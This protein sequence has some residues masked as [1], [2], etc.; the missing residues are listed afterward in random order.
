MQLAH[1]HYHALESFVEPALEPSVEAALESFVEA[2]VGGSLGVLS[3]RQPWSPVWRSC[4]DMLWLRQGCTKVLR[5]R[6]RGADLLS[7]GQGSFLSLRRGRF[8]QRDYSLA[9]SVAGRDT[10]VKVAAPHGPEPLNRN[11]STCVH[12]V[13]VL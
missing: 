4:A 7:R 5:L 9:P 10:A 1:I 8:Q 3:R 11:D 2:S 13:R 6:W 12:V